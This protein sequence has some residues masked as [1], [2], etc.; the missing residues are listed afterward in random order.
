MPLVVLHDAGW[1]Q[2]RAGKEGGDRLAEVEAHTP[3]LSVP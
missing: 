3:V 1:Q 2:V